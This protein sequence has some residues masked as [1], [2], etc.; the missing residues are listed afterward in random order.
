MSDVPVARLLPTGQRNFHQK[1]HW[2][3]V[4]FFDNPQV[5]ELCEAIEANDLS[6]MEQLIQAGADVNARGKGNMTPLMWAFPDNKLKRLQKLLD[7][8]AD[9][10]VKITSNLGVPSGFAVG[11][12]VTTESAQ[13]YF[14]GYF[15]AV[16]QAGGDANIRDGWNMPLIVIIIHA[17]HANSKERCTIALQR[18]AD[19]NSRWAGGTLPMEA[20]TAAGNFDLAMYFIEQGADSTAYRDDKSQR[21]IHALVNVEDEVKLLAPEHQM[22]YKRLFDWLVAHGEDAEVAR[23]D[24]A[25]WAKFSKIPDEFARQAAAEVA[26]REARE[27]AAP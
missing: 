24:F 25:R 18:G 27:K 1:F 14:P 26:A 9:P 7:H 2:E 12:S 11:D 17:T 20:V 5:I 22:S 19:I 16:M 15:Q 6:R 13:S 8:G 21:L 23:A 4:D 3:A 10:N